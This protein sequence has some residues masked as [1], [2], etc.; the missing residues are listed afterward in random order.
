ML[1]MEDQQLE[2]T[3]PRVFVGLKIAPAV[4]RVLAQRAR[5]VE[6]VPSRFVPCEDIHLTLLP[7]WNEDSIPEVIEKLRAT[8]S[9]LAPFPL[10]FT[11]LS[12]W[13]NHRRPRLLCAECTS[14]D[15]LTALQ[16]ALLNVFGQ[17]NDRPFQPH[18]TLARMQRGTKA[19]SAKSELDQD[20]A[21]GHSVDT[22]EL[23]QSP[24][25]PAKGYSILAS[26]PLA[27]RHNKP[28]DDDRPA[29][30]LGGGQAKG[31]QA[32]S[33]SITTPSSRSGGPKCYDS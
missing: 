24:K 8:S 22:V 16:S 28:A 29:K 30:A 31:S 5:R 18:V 33:A 9:R 19:A 26:I 13:P 4:A 14:T 2:A 23:F 25:P 27:A 17:T 12:Y 20:I 10:T 32:A 11:R 21:L 15:E 3:V 1:Q 6:R 7:P